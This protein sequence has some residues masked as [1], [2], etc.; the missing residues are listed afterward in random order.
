MVSSL[1]DTLDS[2]LMAITI[3][4][5][6][7][8][9]PSPDKLDE[10]DDAVV[11][12]FGWAFRFGIGPSESLGDFRYGYLIG[13]HTLNPETIG[14][15]EEKL[16]EKTTLDNPAVLMKAVQVDVNQ[17]ENME[18]IGKLPSEVLSSLEDFV[19]SL[20]DAF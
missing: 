18:K 6:R 13:G 7:N 10:I 8:E 1:N 20:D 4:E 12:R 2:G 15:F 9:R 5:N 17:L 3:I 11:S 19:D 16:K 14:D